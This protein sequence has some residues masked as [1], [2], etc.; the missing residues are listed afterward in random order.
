MYMGSAGVGPHI[1]N[2]DTKV[3]V[4][5]AVHFQATVPTGL[6]L[7]F[8]SGSRRGGVPLPRTKYPPLASSLTELHWLL[9]IR[10][11]LRFL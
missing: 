1:S 11:L 8:S 5:S 7:G 4:N 2:S 9:Y 3:Q 10:K 6:E